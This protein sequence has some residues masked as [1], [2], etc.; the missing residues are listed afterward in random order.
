MARSDYYGYESNEWDAP[1]G[2]YRN[3]EGYDYDSDYHNAIYGEDYHQFRHYDRGYDSDYGNPSHTWGFASMDPEELRRK[4]SL[5]G[6]ASHGGRGS[7]SH[8]SSNRGHRRV[9]SDYESDYDYGLRGHGDTSRRSFASMDP[10]RQRDIASKGRN[11][12]HEHDVAHEWDSEEA[13]EAG[14]LG[15]L[16]SHGG[17]RRSSDY[18]NNDRDS[19]G[20][21]TRTSSDYHED[22][23]GRRGSHSGGRYSDHKE[24][25]NR[26]RSSGGSRRGFAAMSPEQHSR[27]SRMGGEASH[28]G[29]GRR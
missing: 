18:Y 19:R 6:R 9:W 7:E 29:R 2:Y 23:G 27:I 24:R 1:R 13:R 11:A 15:G 20:R 5:G 4:A 8:A 21:F 10:E 12:A 16:A 3:E 25:S 17:H 22:Y 28:G 14:H 26:G